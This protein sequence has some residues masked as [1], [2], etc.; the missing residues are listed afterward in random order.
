MI[1]CLVS[2]VVCCFLQSTV[3]LDLRKRGKD[4]TRNLIF[5]L[6]Y[7]WPLATKNIVTEMVEP[8]GTPFSCLNIEERRL[9]ILTWKVLFSRK[10]LI[11]RSKLPLQRFFGVQ[12]YRSTMW[13]LYAFTMSRAKSPRTCLV[14]FNISLRISCKLL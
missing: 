14:F 5:H 12:L 6:G 2:M 3:C 10:C 8:L 1:L 9:L 4:F 13:W 11:K 7:W